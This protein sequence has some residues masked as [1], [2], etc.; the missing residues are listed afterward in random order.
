[1]VKVY[2]APSFNAWEVDGHQLHSYT[3]ASL[4]RG[5]ISALQIAEKLGLH[6][7]NE[8]KDKPKWMDNFLSNFFIRDGMLY[9]AKNVLRQD[10]R[11]FES[12][13]VKQVDASEIFVFTRFKPE[14]ITHDI[15]ANT[16]ES[17]EKKRFGAN[18]L[19]TRFD[20]DSYFFGG[21]WILL[22]MEAARHYIETQ[23]IEKAAKIISYVEK[24]YLRQGNV[25]IPEQEII[26]PESMEKDSGNYYIKNGYS[27]INDLAWSEAAYVSACT[28]LL[29]AA[30]NAAESSRLKIRA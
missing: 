18:I 17:I 9:K 21:R 8:M 19:P 5:F 12:E 7:P 14:S 2:K 6:I 11:G 22:G 23:E 15:K 30:D 20:G 4:Y 25:M 1:M 24:K 10:G 26:D 29:R 3:L 28:S 16:M 27:A 13:P